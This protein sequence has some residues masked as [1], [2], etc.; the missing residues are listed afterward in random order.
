M[1]SFVHVDQ[2]TSHPGVDR[3]EALFS[4]ARGTRRNF[5][6]ARGLAALLLA[7]IVSSLLVVADRLMSTSA[8]GGLLA[9][10]LVLWVVAFGALAFF[11]DTA[12]SMS[13]HTIGFFKQVAER[14]A[15]NRADAQFLAFA[16]RDSRIMM[17]LVAAAG[18]QEEESSDAPV[19]SKQA[20][21]SIV[22]KRSEAA[23]MP[24]LYEAMRRVN[25]GKYY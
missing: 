8:E 13:L 18:R 1:T 6:G 9:G 3:A 12:R 10:W 11:A 23:R 17:D 24:T 16:Q 5:E 14:R 19:A 2:P 21:I 20:S 4:W 7:A 22:A 15:A 25:L